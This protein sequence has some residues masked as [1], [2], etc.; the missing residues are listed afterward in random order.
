MAAE[1]LRTA[2]R[3]IRARLLSADDAEPT[4]RDLLR[5]FID[6]HD[7]AAFAML[8]ERHQRLVHGA[9]AKVLSDAADTEDAFQAT[10]LVLVPKR[11]R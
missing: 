10:F 4:D 1:A 3:Q 7:E 8:V 2:V 9:L 6:N 5:R 11:A